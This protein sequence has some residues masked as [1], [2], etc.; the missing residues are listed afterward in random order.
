MKSNRE[1]LEK[2]NIKLK[3]KIKGEKIETEKNEKRVEKLSI[4]AVE[5]IEDIPEEKKLFQSQTLNLKEKKPYYN[6]YYKNERKYEQKWSN[7]NN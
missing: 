4:Q 7:V 5:D 6:N 2:E 3:D 1:I